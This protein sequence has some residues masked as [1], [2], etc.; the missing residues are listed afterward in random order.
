[1]HLKLYYVPSLGLNSLTE[2]WLRKADLVDVIIYN[3]GTFP[4]SNYLF[5]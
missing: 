1:M 4:K 2:I 3:L 5:S